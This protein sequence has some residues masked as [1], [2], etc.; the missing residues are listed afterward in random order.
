MTD[1]SNR[2]RVGEHVAIYPRG[3]KKL[4][5]ADFW[6]DGRHCRMSLRTANKR[7][8]LERALRLEVDL[9]SG[10]FQTAPPP[11]TIRQAADDYLGFLETEHR[12]PKTLVKYRGVFDTL[13]EFLVQNHVLRLSQFS[14]TW[15]DRFRAFRKADHHPKTLYTEGIVVKQ[16]FKWARSRKLIAENPIADF[17]LSKPCQEPR[18]GPGLA[19]VDRILTALEEPRRT[20]V[21][22]LAFTG[23]RSGEL[24]RLRPEDLDLEGNWLHVC[25]RPGAETKT[26]LSRKIPIHPRLQPLLAALPS[27]TR[28]WLFTAPAGLHSAPEDGRL[29]VKRLNEAFL[30]VLRQ[31][32]LP[33]GRP[34]GGFTLH[35]LRHFFETF[36]VNAGIPQ[37]VVDTWLGH[38]SD[39]SMASVYYR[40]ADDDSQ[41]FMRRVPFT[42]DGGFLTRPAPRSD[43]HHGVS[44]P[45][46]SSDR[47]QHDAGPGLA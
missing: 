24:Q 17:K 27:R 33:A 13:V 5:C 10:N 1:P 45:P 32:G 29:N 6:R 46:Q 4:W 35:S 18:G 9:A 7:I 34:S 21:A 23:M 2:L 30:K 42:T 37:R 8:A 11:I 26:R 47:V 39:R 41:K 25:S 31:L 43:A 40:L 36:T 14:A 3:K 16:F 44:H 12:A 19:D 20:A 28:P 38:R 15:F 22:V